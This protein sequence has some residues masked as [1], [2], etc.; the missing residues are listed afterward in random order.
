MLLIIIYISMRL[1][2]IC[3]AF[4]CVLS[5]F[6]T[7]FIGGKKINENEI[8]ADRVEYKGII[9]MWQID[10]FEGGKG[11]R[12]QFLLKMARGFEKENQ[13]VLIMVSQ[14]TEEGVEE[15]IEKGN[16]PDIISFGNGINF[17]G[18]ITLNVKRT[19]KGGVVGNKVFATAWCRGGYVLF[20]N[21]NAKDLGEKNELIVSKQKYTQPLI[22]LLYE[23]LEYKNIKIA[24]PLDAYI[25]FVSGKNRFFLGTQR[26]VIRLTNRGFEFIASPLSCYNDLY[27][28]VS[29]VTK[30]E[31]K[32]HYAKNFVEYLL[33]DKVQNSLGEIGM[34]SPYIKAEQKY[35]QLTKMQ[36]EKIKSSISAFISKEEL[37][38]LQNFAVDGING[39][40]DALNKIKNIAI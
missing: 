1:Y 7:I 4:L 29:V 6:F 17:D 26:D 11:S 8:S 18:A 23:G 15:Q 9:K 39:N 27:Q 32:A 34:L 3:F 2:K 36:E 21:P 28:Y 38:A 13:G 19:V 31:S 25:K 33:S 30:D 14:L 22:S 10:S 24:S 40:I 16:Y 35:E 37:L 12:R 20:E 5:V